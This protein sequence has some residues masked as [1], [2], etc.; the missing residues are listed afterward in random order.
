MRSWLLCTLAGALYFLGFAGFEI[1]PL[2]LVAFAPALWVFDP[3][4][5]GADLSRRRVFFLAVWFGLVTNLGGYHWLIETLQVYSGFPWVLCVLFA[6]ILCAYQGG[7]IALTM[8]LWR[9]ARARG[10]NATLSFC[11]VLAG[12]EQ[13]YPLL[14][15]HYFANS[16]HDLPH[17]IQAADLGGPV[18]VS[19]VL[20]ASSGGV[21]ELARSR[22]SGL[23]LVWRPLALVALVWVAN[24]GYGAYRIG[25]VDARAADAPK[26]RV[27]VVQTNMGIFA[28]RNDIDESIKRH[29]EQSKKL[30]QQGELDLLVWPESA[31]GWYIYDGTTNVKANV[32]GDVKT[33]TLFGGLSRRGHWGKVKRF[34]TAFMTNA[35]GD[36]VG[37]Y[38]K[39]YL[40][41]FGEYIPGG[42]AFP[43]L[44]AMSPHTG[45]FSPGYRTNSVPLGDYRLAVLI[46]YE[47]ILPAFVRRF[48]V[49][50]NPHLLVNITNDAWFG[51]TIEPWQ[52]LA[53]AQ[54]RSVEHH[55]ALVRATNSGVSAV[56]DPVGRVIAQSG[57]FERAEFATEVPMMQEQTLYTW[58]GDWPGWL[59]FVTG[60][61]CAFG[62]FAPRRRESILGV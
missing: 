3:L 22:Y 61:W 5:A 33:P 44:Y 19:V 50:T 57:V 6:A 7:S 56:V 48:V 8:W 16:L 45:R 11:A 47:D 26:Q 62:P 15:E 24:L 58:L 27:G 2:S 59:G 55:R 1:W 36:I 60:L 28:K 42:E 29:R 32:L 13:V 18:L 12:V 52:H 53:L 9:R 14:F 40:L 39:I 51:D 34:N 25:E 4:G 38:D 43:Q 46:C 31:Y 41:A 35:D 21:Y 23:P 49:E 10:W 30:E 54:F 17:A 20:G 37:T